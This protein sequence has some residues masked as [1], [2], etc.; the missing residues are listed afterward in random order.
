M[1]AGALPHRAGESRHL[2]PAT[3]GFLQAGLGEQLLVDEAEADRE[4]PGHGDLS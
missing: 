2:M 3:R 1:A 4:I